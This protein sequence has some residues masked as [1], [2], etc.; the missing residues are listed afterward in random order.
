MARLASAIAV[1]GIT[2]RRVLLWRL[3][4]CCGG[5]VLTL[6]SERCCCYSKDLREAA[7]R[8]SLFSDRDKDASNGTSSEVFSHWIHK[9]DFIF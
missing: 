2:A 6:I 5:L 9:R 8:N 1:A 7:P 4:D 3:R